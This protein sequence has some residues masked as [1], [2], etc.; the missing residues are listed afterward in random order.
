M[1][2]RRPCPLRHLFPLL[3]ILAAGGVLAQGAGDGGRELATRIVRRHVAY[4][5]NDDGSY[6]ETRT[7][8]LQVLR[9][10]AIAG[11]K[12]A[13]VSFSTSVQTADVLEAYTLKK[14]GRQLRASD[15]N[16]QVSANTGRGG[17]PAYSDWTT[18][19]VVFPDV[20][21]GDTLVFGYR[22]TTREPIYPGHFSLL[23][24]L[25][26]SV[27]FDEA[28]IA[29]DAPVALWRNVEARGMTEVG[30]EE[31]GGRR[32]VEWAWANPKPP[33]ETRRD[34]SVVDL[35]GE[36]G[37][38]FSTFRDLHEMAAAYGARA[39]PKAAVTPR[40]T[41]LAEEI[42]GQ[43]KAPRD[44]A[45]ALYD[46]VAGNITYAGNCI[47]IG[48]VVPRD[49]DYVLDNRMGDCKDHATLLQALLAARGIGSTQALVNSGPAY[50]LPRI[51]VVATVNHVINYLPDFDL[52][53]DSTARHIPFGMLP[54]EAADKPVLH[55]DGSRRET[56]TPPLP[57]GTNREVTRTRIGIAADGSVKGE[58]EVELRGMFA[59]DARARAREMTKEVQA[60]LVRDAYRG[61][62]YVASGTYEQEDPKP[63]TDRFR[64]KVSFRIEKLLQFPGSLGIGPYFHSGAPI[65][66]YIAAAL[67]QEEKEHDT[68]CTSGTTT[69]EY[70][71]ELPANMQVIAIPP[72]ARVSNSFLDYQASYK[73]KGRTLT[74]R[75]MLEDRTRGHV[76]SPRL[77]AEYRDFARKVM[78]NLKAV[79]LYK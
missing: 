62:G 65:V 35:E 53:A 23:E 51:P 7:A 24:T 36:A 3:F 30:R 19:S 59:V 31:K 60:D 8:A 15:A 64:Y 13:S 50:R 61:M 4:V 41:R 70:V 78:E 76:C 47:G 34:W 17:A 2:A 12:Q 22:I 54:F 55:V 42:A 57:V 39:L 45:R 29:I 40:V 5:V 43:A 63:L 25:P 46:W 49:L 69:E 71:F 9:E 21:V 26:R 73:R 20:E 68:A 33:K 66:G 37:V 74:V 44:A 52:Y 6:A 18:L 67:Q 28:R 32:R 27:A 75:R 58:M 56:R 79:V 72:D 48:A 11:S 14:D 1:S 16:Y 38:S 77:T 10:A